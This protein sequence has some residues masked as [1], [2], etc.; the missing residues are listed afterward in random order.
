MASVVYVWIPREIYPGRP[1]FFGFSP[2][3][4]YYS[5]VKVKKPEKVN[6]YLLKIA[7]KLPVSKFKI[8]HFKGS[9]RFVEYYEYQEV[10]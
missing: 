10:S 2:T 5:K 7:N 4:V 8:I 3:W 9:R 1:P 6:D